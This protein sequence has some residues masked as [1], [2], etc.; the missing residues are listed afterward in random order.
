[1]ASCAKLDAP[2]GARRAQLIV[3]FLGLALGWPALGQQNS[4]DA[5]RLNA[6]QKA[7]DSGGGKKRKVVARPR[8]PGCRSGIFCA[9]WRWPGSNTGGI[10]SRFRC[11]T[12]ENPNDPRFLVELAGI[13]YKQNNYSSAERNLRAA[14]RLGARYL[15][16]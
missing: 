6:A 14:L 11:R 5:A 9:G 8:K 4:P 13:D 3:F 16:A 2:R 10:A 1:M 7:F 15:C 12:S